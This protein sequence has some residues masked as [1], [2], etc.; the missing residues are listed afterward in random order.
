MLSQPI[1]FADLQRGGILS[2]DGAWY[3]VSNLWDL[4]E[5]AAQKINKIV[6]DPKGFRVT[7]YSASRYEKIAKRLEKMAAKEG[8]LT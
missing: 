8:L 4:P 1:D 7:L 2:K 6:H 3:R 5:H